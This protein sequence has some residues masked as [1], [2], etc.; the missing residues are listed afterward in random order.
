ML[1][2]GQLVES[3]APKRSACDLFVFSAPLFEKE[4]GVGL[5][6]YILDF[7]NPFLKH[8]SCLRPRLT[9]DDHPID[10]IQIYFTNRANQRFKGNEADRRRYCSKL[11][12]PLDIV[13]IFYTGPKPNVSKR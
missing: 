4:S 1:H 5:S 6:A 12:N 9:S 10:A 13:R 2:L 11:I 7:F 3:P 8:R